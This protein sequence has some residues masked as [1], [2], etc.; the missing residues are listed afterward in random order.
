M[1]FS[2]SAGLTVATRVTAV[3]LMGLVSVVVARSLGPQGKGVIASLIAV[4]AIAQQ[5][6]HLGIYASIIRFVGGDRKL[7]DKAAG[8]SLA[9]GIILGLSL[10]ILL[11]V[12]GFLAPQVFGNIPFRYVAVYSL[13]VPFSILIILFQGVL[14]SVN[15]VVP[16]NILL[17]S[18]SFLIFT[19]SLILLKFLG[20]GI[21]GL[22]VFLVF[23]EAAISVLYVGVGYVTEKFRLHLDF[24]FIRRMM[25]YGIKVYVATSLTILVFKFDILLVN[26]FKG[27][28]A[29]GLYSVSAQLAEL[30]Y[31]APATVALLFFPA[32]TQMGEGSRLFAKKVLL[33]LSVIMVFV[34]ITAYLISP[35]LVTGLFTEKFSGAVKPFR[36]LVPG[37]FFISLETILMN[38]YA[39]R[40]MPLYAVL[41]PFAGLFSNIVLNILFIPRYG[42]AAAAATSTFSYTLMFFLLAAYFMRGK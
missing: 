10:T 22:V 16:Y 18:R 4:V 5:F 15:R 26:F 37:I 36:I 14:L 13:A 20:L 9:L 12:V 39:S 8:N 35:S 41:T 33:A 17:F 11:S 3:F 23:V 29:A 21:M 40:D 2:L 19:G 25:G 34:S 32:A 30:V 31:L 7:Y 28:A 38:Y 1:R 6:G 27:S 24:G 42:I